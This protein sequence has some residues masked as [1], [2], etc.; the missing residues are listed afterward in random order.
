M[1]TSR[2]V[3]ARR[4]SGWTVAHPADEIVTHTALR[5]IAALCVVLYHASLGFADVDVPLHSGFASHGYLFVDMFFMLSGYIISLKYSDWFA[6]GV[7]LPVF[8]RFM[9]LRFAR[10]YPNYLF[11]FLF[12]VAVSAAQALRHGQVVGQAVGPEAATLWSFAMHVIGLQW[13]FPTPVHW[14]IPLWSISIEFVLYALFPLM[15]V[16][17]SRVP[18]VLAGL[19]AVMALSVVAL[20]AANDTIDVIEGPLS[21]LRGIA[22]FGIGVLI[23]S[24]LPSPDGVGTFLLSALQSASLIATVSLVHLGQEAAAI[25]S[26][27]PLIW[28]TQTNRGLLYHLARLKPFH[29]AGALSF[30]VYL[31]HAPLFVLP[32]LVWWKFRGAEGASQL[33]GFLVVGVCLMAISLAAASVALRFVEVP[34]QRWLRRQL[35]H[36]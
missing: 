21:I 12:A 3:P 35:L 10:L 6:P 29:R 33:E 31:S 28:L 20:I 14:N 18:A 30:S 9:A 5:G 13:I 27:A 8:G 22:S 17:L 25:A 19:S 2:P 24:R 32:N 36:G 11:W 23:V 15:G 16:W 34:A 7:T 26:F 1:Q 4:R